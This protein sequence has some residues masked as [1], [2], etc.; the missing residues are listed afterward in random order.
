MNFKPLSFAICAAM[1]F[2]SARAQQV[3][4]YAD[5]NYSGRSMALSASTP[6]VGDEWNDKISSIRVPAGMQVE[7]FWDMNYKGISK[8]ITADMAFVGSDWNDKASSIKITRLDR[9]GTP[10]AGAPKPRPTQ[11]FSSGQAQYSPFPNVNGQGSPKPAPE[12]TIPNGPQGTMYFRYTDQI[13]CSGDIASQMH[14]GDRIYVL[15]GQTVPRTEGMS[16]DP[17]APK[18]C[19]QTFIVASVDRNQVH[20]TQPLTEMMRDRNNG[21]FSF[22]VVLMR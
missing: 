11:P 9:P 17:N 7:L 13:Q 1:C 8:I 10:S 18:V 12:A 14:P 16:F 2:L 19:G 4:F 5:A 22:R 15:P 6:W 3:T 21:S 20:F